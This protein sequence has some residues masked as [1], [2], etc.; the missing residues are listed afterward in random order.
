MFRTGLG[1]IADRGR[2]AP[3]PTRRGCCEG[4][5]ASSGKRLHLRR[6]RRSRALIEN[7]DR[8]VSRLRS[9]MGLRVQVGGEGRFFAPPAGP[10]ELGPGAE[11]E[12]ATCGFSVRFS[13]R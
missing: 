9:A 1:E 3:A 2:P 13:T 4:L 8:R 11:A 6:A 5:R 10:P 7:A 12:P